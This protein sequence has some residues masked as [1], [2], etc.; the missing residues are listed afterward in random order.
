MNKNSCVLQKTNKTIYV[1]NTKYSSPVA[2]SVNLN[3]QK[4]RKGVIW[5]SYVDLS[6]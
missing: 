3:I 6:G 4:Y 1:L 2:S 5:F